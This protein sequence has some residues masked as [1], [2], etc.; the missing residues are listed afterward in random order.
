MYVNEIYLE[1][2]I[3]ILIEGVVRFLIEYISIN[4]LPQYYLLLKIVPNS[5]WNLDMVG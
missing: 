1:I 2:V 4:E 3:V 5:D